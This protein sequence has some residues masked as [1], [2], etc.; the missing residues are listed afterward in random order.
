MKRTVSVLVAIVIMLSISTVF[1]AGGKLTLYSSQPD[2]DAARTVAEYQKRHPDVSVQIFRS[3]T[4]EVMNKLTAEFAAG[5]PKPDVLLIADVV[6]MERL[7]QDG[8]LLPHPGADVRAYS[9]ETYDRERTYFGTKLITTGIVYHTAAK[10]RPGSWADL[11]D[12]VRKG[13]LIMPSPLYS[14]AAAI[15]LGVLSRY[16]DLGWRF[17]E[18]LKANEAVAVRGNGAVLK[19]V[20]SGEKSYGVLVDFMALNAKAKGSPVEF[21]LPKE[22]VTAV[23]E[24]VAILKTTRNPEAARAFVDFLLS[25]EG[26]RLAASQGYLPAHTAV[27]PPPGFPKP[28]DVKFLPMDAAA[29]LSTMPADLKRFADLFGR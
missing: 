28:G 12:P 17:F 3:G 15:T 24:P 7:K 16:A 25:E 4:T 2:Q 21:V 20:A 10:S 18:Q 11:A 1:A 14:G 29:I 5:D 22:G 8:R 13:Q 23:T 26:Q 9:P 6:S 27:P 19:A